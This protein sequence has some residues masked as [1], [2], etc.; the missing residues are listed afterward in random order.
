MDAGIV[1]SCKTKIEDFSLFLIRNHLSLLLLLSLHP[2]SQ[3]KPTHVF[4]HLPPRVIDSGATD[5]MT[6][7]SRL[8]ITFMSHPTTSTVTLADGSTSCVLGSRKIHPTP[9][10]TLTSILSLP[11]FSFNLIYVSK[12]THTLNCNI[13]FF[14]LIIV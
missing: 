1:G 6:G 5:H 2:L 4:F 7:N 8:F 11:Q 12:P 9:L 14:F 3:V 13:S 10:I